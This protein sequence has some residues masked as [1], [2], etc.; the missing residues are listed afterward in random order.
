VVPLQISDK[1]QYGTL[2]CIIC[3]TS[4]TLCSHLFCHIVTC[5][6]KIAPCCQSFACK[7]CNVTLVTFYFCG[8]EHGKTHCCWRNSF[9]LL[10]LALTLFSRSE[11]SSGITCWGFLTPNW[12][13]CRKQIKK[14]GLDYGYCWK[15]PLRVWETSSIYQM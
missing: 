3:I 11:N 7:L 6:M 5:L 10:H 9:S 8:S 14:T 15:W 12:V 1:R 2:H 13:F 4:R